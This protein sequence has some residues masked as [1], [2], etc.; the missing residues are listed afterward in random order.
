M[1][2]TRVL[3]SGVPLDPAPLLPQSRATQLSLLWPSIPLEGKKQIWQYDVI[4]ILVHLLKDKVKEV[5]AN[6]AGA[7]MYATV[8][9]EGEAACRLGMSAR[10]GCPSCRCWS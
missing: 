2:P 10:A 7:L 4:P 8:T 3:S 5:Q 6:A 1:V 9:T